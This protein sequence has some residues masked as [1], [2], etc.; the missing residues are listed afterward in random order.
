MSLPSN[1]MYLDYHTQKSD[2]NPFK[3]SKLRNKDDSH[4][5]QKSIK[6]KSIQLNK[7]KMFSNMYN[8][9][10]SHSHLLLIISV[11]FVSLF[12]III[13][14]V[15]Q[16][17]IVDKYYHSFCLGFLCLLD[18]LINREKYEI[19]MQKDYFTE[20]N[21]DSLFNQDYKKPLINYT[22]E[23]QNNIDK[24]NKLK[25]DLTPIM[26]QKRDLLIYSITLGILSFSTEMLIFYVLKI[27]TDVFERNSSIGFALIS[28]EYI[29]IRFYY[30]MEE[31]RIE[32]LNFLGLLMIFASF[33]FISIEYLSLSIGGLAFFISSLRFSKF[34]LLVL[35]N[36]YSNLDYQLVYLLSNIV[37]FL[38]GCICIFSSIVFYHHTFSI[39]FEDV[40]LMMS[41]SVLYYINGKYF[42]YYDR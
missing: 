20:Y 30:S 28:F 35:L 10:D 23:E 7:F 16:T 9:V 21:E 18:Y 19:K 5:K 33:L 17:Y 34:Y 37:D 36:K 12:Y 25:L 27:T 39:Y 1:E 22:N 32:F 40:F 31:V 13:L 24:E 3:K 42:K 8:S 6:K 11:L 4:Y 38:I 41:A 2:E 14:R 26:I 15:R 29:F